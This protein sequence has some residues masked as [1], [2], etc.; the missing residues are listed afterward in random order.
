MDPAISDGFHVRLQDAGTP[1]MITGSRRLATPLHLEP[2]LTILGNASDS[3]PTRQVA[4]PPA[5]DG[6]QAGEDSEGR[7]ADAADPGAAALA[8]VPL[9]LFD[10]FPGAVL[11]LDGLGRIVYANGIVELRL[12]TIRAELVGRFAETFATAGVQ[13]MNGSTD[14]VQEDG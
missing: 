14:D 2:E 9:R 7:L 4:A 13:G 1:G 10:Q 5:M 3:S 6:G 11:L 12:D 8:A